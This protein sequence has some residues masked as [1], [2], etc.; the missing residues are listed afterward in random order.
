LGPSRFKNRDALNILKK[1]PDISVELLCRGTKIR[2]W[3]P[4][5]PKQVR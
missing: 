1:K 4:L 3:D 2:T 5:L